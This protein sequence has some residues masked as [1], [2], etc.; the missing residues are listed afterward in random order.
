MNVQT[1]VQIHGLSVFVA[2]PSFWPSPASGHESVALL[3]SA[4]ICIYLRAD[5][6]VCMSVCVGS[7]SHRDKMVQYSY[8]YQKLISNF[9]LTGL[10]T[11]EMCF[12]EL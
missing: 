8:M 7:K 11:F 3:G 5:S 10:S 9:T 2:F 1:S 4:K 12:A 6:R